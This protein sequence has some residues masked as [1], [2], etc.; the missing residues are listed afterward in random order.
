MRKHDLDVP[1]KVRKPD[2]LKTIDDDN[3][4]KTTK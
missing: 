1:E 4:D 2:L 3:I